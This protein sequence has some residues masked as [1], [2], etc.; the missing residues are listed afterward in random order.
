[1]LKQALFGEGDVWVPDVKDEHS[2]KLITVI[3]RFVFDG[4]VKGEGLPLNPRSCLAT[5]AEA[6]SARHNERKMHNRA[7]IG[8]AAV[9]RYMLAGLED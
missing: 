3:P 2:A 1:V 8:H 6:A 9:R 4:I 7:C 5:N